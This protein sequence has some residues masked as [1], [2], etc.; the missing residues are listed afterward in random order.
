ML[1][2]EKYS[3]QEKTILQRFHDRAAA[4]MSDIFNNVDHRHRM[5]HTIRGSPFKLNAEYYG[6]DGGISTFQSLFQD[7]LDDIEVRIVLKTTITY[8]NDIFY[9]FLIF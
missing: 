1:G 4:R 2:S 5:L 9:F 8:L 3:Q 7:I 6:L